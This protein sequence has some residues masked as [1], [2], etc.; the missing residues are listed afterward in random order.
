ML[1]RQNG[2]FYICKL[3]SDS[4]VSMP[5]SICNSLKST[6]G[7][8]GEMEYLKCDKDLFVLLLF[9]QI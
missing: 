8:G 6:F 7:S 3:H 5:T 4:V 1:L 2:S 9:P